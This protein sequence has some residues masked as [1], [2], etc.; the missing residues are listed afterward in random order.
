MLLFQKYWHT[1]TDLKIIPKNPILII[2]KLVTESIIMVLYY[3][4]ER[5]N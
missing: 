2:K 1:Y 4:V 3:M 5:W